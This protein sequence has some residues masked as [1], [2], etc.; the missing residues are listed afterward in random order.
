M[1]EIESH[2]EFHLY[3]GNAVEET[4]ARQGELHLRA[5]NRWT[6]TGNTLRICVVFAK[7]YCCVTSPITLAAKCALYNSLYARI[8]VQIQPCFLHGVYKLAMS[9]FFVTDNVTRI[10]GV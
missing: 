5:V 8:V 10:C 4:A 3:A 2:R 9:R 1:I 6:M 7:P